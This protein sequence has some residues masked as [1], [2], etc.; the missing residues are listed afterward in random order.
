MIADDVVDD[1]LVHLLVVVDGNVAETGHSAQVLRQIGRDDSPL[2]KDGEVLPQCVRQ[3]QPFGGDDVSR[4]IDRG[5][6]ASL[7]IENRQLFGIDATELGPWLI[8]AMRFSV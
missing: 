5:L 4:E 6:R 7:E 2:R 8:S 3:T 1:R